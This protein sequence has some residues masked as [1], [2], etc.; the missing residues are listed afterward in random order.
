MVRTRLSEEGGTAASSWAAV[1]L[2]VE[3]RKSG[4]G[5]KIHRYFTVALIG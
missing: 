4:R 5:K 1:M 2:F 3:I